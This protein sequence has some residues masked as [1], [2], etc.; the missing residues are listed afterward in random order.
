[1]ALTVVDQAASSA[2]NFALAFVVAHYSDAHV[3]GVFAIV[4]T[5]YILTQGLV[6]SLTSD[7]LLTRHDADDGV[8]DAYERAGFLSALICAVGDLG[9]APRGQPGLAA[10]S[11]ASPSSS[12]RVSFPLLA[13]QDFA[14]YIGISRYN[15]AYAVWLDAAWLVLFVAATWSC[16]TQGLL[17]LPW[18]FGSW[19][20]NAVR[21]SGSTPLWNHLSAPPPRAQ[22]GLLVPAA[23]APSACASPASGCSSARGPTWPSTSSSCIFSVAVIGQF[24]LAQ[25]AFGPVTV[26][27]QGIVTAMVAL[28]ARHFQVDSARRCASS[29]SAVW[30]RRPSCW[31]GS[32]S[33]TSSPS[34]P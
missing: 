12:S 10:P 29:C 15:P 24:K 22:L 21:L 20:R 2:S 25:V 6:R 18:L 9:G 34:P 23:S 32:S 5:T 26:L 16:A 3:L 11:S 31:P 27:Y 28:A 1:M 19:T 33:S 17:S 14:R 8:M 13:C 4:T 7:C 30:R